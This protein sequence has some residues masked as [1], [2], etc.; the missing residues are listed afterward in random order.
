MNL[1]SLNCMTWP[2][3]PFGYLHFDVGYAIWMS[4][5]ERS[6]VDMYVCM[7]VCMYIRV[8]GSDVNVSEGFHSSRLSR[9]PFSRLGKELRQSNNN[10]PIQI[11]PLNFFFYC[12]PSSLLFSLLLSLH[13]FK[14]RSQGAASFC[15]SSTC[16]P[17]NKCTLIKTYVGNIDLVS[18]VNMSRF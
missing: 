3:L 14:S 5:K 10:W 13:L 7:Y 15:R 12:D 9:Q 17:R 2:L 18:K 16:R 4:T 8:H 11:E 6:T 1:L